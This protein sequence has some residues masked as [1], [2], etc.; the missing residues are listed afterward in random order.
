M[1]RYCCLNDKCPDLAGTVSSSGCPEDAMDASKDE[2]VVIV[3]KDMT[4]KGGD[5][6]MT[7]DDEDGFSNTEDDCPNIAGSANG[8][9]DADGDGTADKFDA[10]P[11][12]RGALAGCP[13]MDS[14]GIADYKDTCPNVAG[15][16]LN[17][18]CPEVAITTTSTNTNTYNSN[19]PN[20][21][22]SNFIAERHMSL[23]EN[24]TKS[25]QFNV[26]SDDITTG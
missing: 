19:T 18:G 7:D 20:T 14:D 26:L 6:L 9:P 13:D 24:A 12:I 25:V 4:E 23:M 16:A 3:E 5:I 21:S 1:S 11:G 17:S 22:S 15:S 10:C 8:C 2:S